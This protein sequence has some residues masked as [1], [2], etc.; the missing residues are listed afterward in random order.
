MN[1]ICCDSRLE[2]YLSQAKPNTASTPL[3]LTFFFWNAGNVMQKSARG[4]LQSLLYQIFCQDRTILQ[5][6]LS[7]RLGLQDLSPHHV[8]SL[9]QLKELLKIAVT[10]S[11]RRCCFF[12]DGLDEFDEG[13]WELLD[14][15]DSLKQ[16][17]NVKICVSSRPLHVFEKSFEGQAKLRLQD[18]TRES[19]STYVKH[20]LI[21]DERVKRLLE[22]KPDSSDNL[23]RNILERAQGVFLWVTL[24]VNDLWQGVIN[25]DDWEMLLQRLEDC[26][27]E[28]E[29]V[30][31][32]MWARYQGDLKRYKEKAEYYFRLVLFKET[33]LL[34]FTICV[35]E[36]L[37]TIYEDSTP[38]MEE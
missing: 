9:K 3:V 37:Q 12:I 1:L 29:Q 8:W 26:P 4:L 30:Y 23:I 14:M 13:F 17:A 38:C 11:S 16:L 21:D 35:R 22:R 27:G 24:V 10:I 15:L 25:N 7:S 28:V 34:Q 6:V 5:A 33:S 18:L 20:R 32:R 31:E 2:R 19:I 36:E